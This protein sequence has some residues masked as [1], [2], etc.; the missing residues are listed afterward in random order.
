MAVIVALGH[1]LSA[2]AL[3]GLG[4]IQIKVVI[5]LYDDLLLYNGVL[6]FIR[7][8]GFAAFTAELA[9]RSLPYSGCYKTPQHSSLGR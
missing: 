5:R 7:A 3:S 6:R 8:Q 9:T 1:V 4:F 2:K